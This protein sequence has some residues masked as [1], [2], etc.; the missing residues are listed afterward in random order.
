LIEDI[1]ETDLETTLKKVKDLI[2]GAYAL[3]VVDKNNPD[4]IIA[5]KL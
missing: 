1:F 5:I 2:T 4:T 3:A